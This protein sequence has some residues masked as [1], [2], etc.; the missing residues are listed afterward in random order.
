MYMYMIVYVDSDEEAMVIV[1]R[2]IPPH[3]VGFFC[4]DLGDPSKLAKDWRGIHGIQAQLTGHC[5]QGSLSRRKPQ[6]LCAEND[7]I[8][9]QTFPRMPRFL[10]FVSAL[11]G[12]FIWIR[13]IVY[14]ATPKDRQVGNLEDMVENIIYTILERLVWSIYLFDSFEGVL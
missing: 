7:G 1:V 9:G 8:F 4:G 6:G 14:I 10:R 13:L 5:P 11:P 2:S 3:V 12:W